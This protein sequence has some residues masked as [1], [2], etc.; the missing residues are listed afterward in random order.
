MT[1]WQFIIMFFGLFILLQVGDII[2]TTVKKQSP[3]T[4]HVYLHII[5][6]EEQS[7]D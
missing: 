1:T 5:N 4:V 3:Q 2:F 6:K 7:N